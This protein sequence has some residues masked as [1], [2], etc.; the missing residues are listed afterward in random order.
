MQVSLLPFIGTNHTLSGS[1]IN[2]I[3]FNVLAGYSLGV[4]ALE[5][6]GFANL[7]RGNVKGVQAAGFGNFVGK[8]VAGVQGAGFV[9]A[10]FRD[11]EG[12]QASGFANFVGRDFQGIQAA[13]FVNVIGRNAKNTI[14]ASGFANVAIGDTKGIQASGFA[15]VAANHLKGIQASGFFN[16]AQIHTRG[17]QVSLVN[18]ADSSG[19]FP[20]GLFS[21]VRANGYRRLEI[22][23]ND[24]NYTHVVFK[25]G[26]QKFY[27]FLTI[28]SNFGYANKPLFTLGY[29]IG[30]AQNWNKGWLTNADISYQRLV[31]SFNNILESRAYI[32][33]LDLA[34]E[35]KIGKQ[36]SLFVGPSW[37]FMNA[38]AAYLNIEKSKLINILPNAT[39]RSGYHL[40]NWIGFQGGIRLLNKGS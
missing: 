27:N 3:S 26:V 9:N 1:V 25:S 39:L 34:I 18:Y 7:I 2:T 40:S 37:T 32:F 30:T 14:Q 13:G 22:G 36:V 17:V 10:T 15:N 28:G 24:I 33:R 35:K 29:G 11:T 23:S 20:I 5:V 8:D 31:D 6:G 38:P 19:G 12:I 16:Y 21:F 4:S